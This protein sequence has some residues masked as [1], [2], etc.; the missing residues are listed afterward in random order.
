MMPD[1]FHTVVR[2]LAL[3]ASTFPAQAL[4]CLELALDIDKR[5]EKI[6]FFTDELRAAIGRAMD[7]PDI[8]VRERAVALVHRLGS[9]GL[10]EYRDLLP[11]S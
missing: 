3:I 5:G 7:T 10:R 1:P 4:E 9:F 2:R 6:R 8:A 11:G